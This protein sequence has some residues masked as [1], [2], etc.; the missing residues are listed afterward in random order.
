MYSFCYLVQ[1][2]KVLR[3]DEIEIKTTSSYL[4]YQQTLQQHRMLLSKEVTGYD[5]Q[6]LQGREHEETYS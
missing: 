6:M 1:F 3:Y 5:W 4:K 2:D